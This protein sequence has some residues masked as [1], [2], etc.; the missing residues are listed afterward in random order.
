METAIVEHHQKFDSKFKTN[1]LNSVQS[2]AAASGA[3]ATILD[4]LFQLQSGAEV[5]ANVDAA[6]TATT[7][8][9]IV[10]LPDA[11]LHDLSERNGDLQNDH[12]YGDNPNN[13]PPSDSDV[14]DDVVDDINDYNGKLNSILQIYF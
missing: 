7:K 6:I 1:A 8:P 9:D 2:S 10:S 4:G 3:K 5:I 12:S 13:S 14:G 11:P